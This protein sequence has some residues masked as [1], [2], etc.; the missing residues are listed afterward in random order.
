M[1]YNIIDSGSSGNAVIFNDVVMVDCGI[2]FKKVAPYLHQLQLVLL[3]HIHSD[4]L[5]KVTI[6]RLAAE[7][8][9][10]RWGCADWLILPLVM[11]GVNK[12]NIDV[13]SGELGYSYVFGTVEMFLLE[14]DVPNCGYRI[15][16]GSIQHPPVTSIIYAT[17]TV[18]LPDLEILRDCDYYFVEA[19]YRDTEELENRMR[20]KQEAGEYTHEKRVL[21]Y[22]MSEKHVLDWLVR[23]GK[24]SSQHV[25]LH[26]HKER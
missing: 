15:R 20:I 4:H 26:E 2:A 13:M 11:C 23:N 14:H 22:H 6:K 18:S 25:F 17:D 12:R 9:S 10:L 16:L 8:P 7:R 21:E 3:T 1:D 19:N 24:P 5:N